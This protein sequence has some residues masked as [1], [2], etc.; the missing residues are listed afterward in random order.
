MY[1]INYSEAWKMKCQLIIP[2]FFY[3]HAIFN[4]HH[5]FLYVGTTCILTGMIC[6]PMVMFS[7]P[8]DVMCIPAGMTCIP[9]VTGKQSTI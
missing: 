8:T 1:E 6:I 7:M 9:I 2:D 5:E 3:L 4:L